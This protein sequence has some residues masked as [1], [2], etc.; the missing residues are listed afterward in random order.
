MHMSPTK[1]CVL[2]VSA[3]IFLFL[4]AWAKHRMAPESTPVARGAAYAAVRGCVGC[5]GDPEGPLTNTNESICSSVKS[6]SWHP[7]Y[8]AECADVMAY[9]ETIRLRR[10]LDDR[11]KLGIDS[12]LIAGEK[13]ARKYHCFQCHGHL[14]QGGF[15][16]PKSL[17]GYVPGYFGSDFKILTRNADPDSVREWIMHGMDST[18]MEEPVLGRAAA[19]FFGRQAVRMPSYESL[20]PVEIEILVNYVIA[21]H[22]Y[23]PMTAKIIRSYRERSQTT[24]GLVSF[25]NGVRLESIQP[26]NGHR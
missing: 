7:D 10:T 21:L 2:I 16:N 11:A 19:F 4:V 14:G 17:K 9:F 22:Q 18:I 13:L 26:E 20:E 3:G 6:E 23:G 8:D 25:D 15:E 5:H 24:E 1:F 12:P